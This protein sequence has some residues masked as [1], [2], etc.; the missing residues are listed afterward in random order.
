MRRAI[1]DSG[2]KNHP[3]VRDHSVQ[4]V[5]RIGRVK[6]CH[7]ACLVLAV[8]MGCQRGSTDGAIGVDAQR[9]QADLAFIAS[10]PRPPGS[11]HWQATQD[12]CADALA[13][14]GLS[15]RRQSYETGVNVI[16]QKTGS[17]S[18]EIVL[19]GAHYDS[20]A[21]CPGA[22]DNASGVAAVLEVARAVAAGEHRRSLI[23]AC[24]DEEER[25]YLGSKAFVGSLGGSSRLVGHFNFEMIAF[26]TSASNSQTIPAGLNQLFPAQTAAVEANQRRGDFIAIVADSGSAAAVERLATHASRFGL[27][28]QRLDI[29]D[30]LR[31]SSLISDLRRSDHAS[32]W[33]QSLPSVMLTDTANFRNQNYHCQGGQ[34]ALDTL[35]LAFAVKVVKATAAAVTNLLA[36]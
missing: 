20:L 30:A 5:D 10:E 35:N 31:T 23:F 18:D 8:G 22:D 4:I 27:P 14:A 29:P 34:D 2:P 25:G 7:P 11:P 6:L 1:V 3:R 21:S 24:W 9:Y 32:F 15:V 12:R 26:A 28:Y 19:V 36:E 17:N 13:A 16:G 33:D